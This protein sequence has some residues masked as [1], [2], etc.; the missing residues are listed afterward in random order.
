MDAGEY[1]F[2]LPKIAR[3]SDYDGKDKL[4]EP[5]RQVAPTDEGEGDQADKG[6]DSESDP[7]SDSDSDDSEGS[8]DGSNQDDISVH[9]D[10][11][12]VGNNQQ[13]ISYERI[14]YDNQFLS[15]GFAYYDYDITRNY[16][17]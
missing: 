15:G 7:E 12:N 9:E 17:S 1:S 11:E 8:S 14:L 10:Q 6:S 2:E 3:E 5:Q 13:Q 16:R 4:Y